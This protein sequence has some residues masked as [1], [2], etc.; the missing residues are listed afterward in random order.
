MD[1]GR[2]MAIA[3]GGAVSSI[4]VFLMVCYELIKGKK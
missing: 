4:A 1:D 2:G 3:I